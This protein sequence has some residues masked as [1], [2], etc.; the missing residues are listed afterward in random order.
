MSYIA[1]QASHILNQFAFSS[2]LCLRAKSFMQDH[3]HSITSCYKST[4]IIVT[5]FRCLKTG[6]LSSQSCQSCLRASP[7]QF[8]LRSNTPQIFSD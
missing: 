2:V 1:T 3:S 7:C 8:P 5:K 4:P 6:S